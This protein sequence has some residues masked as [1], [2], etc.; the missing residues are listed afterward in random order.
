MRRENWQLPDSLR[1]AQIHLRVSN[2]E[3]AV[4]FYRDLLGF[5]QAGGGDGASLLSPG[6]G[7]SPRIK[8]TDAS[9]A[10][11]RRRG[12]PGLFHVAFRYPDRRALAQELQ[13]LLKS[14]Y[15]VQGAADH[16]VSDALYL[17]DPDGNGVELYC[18]RPRDSW[19]WHGG[20]LA[21][22]T[23][24]LD[25]EALIAEAA[26]PGVGSSEVL[27]DIG[28]IHLQVSDL[29]RSGNFYHDVLGFD[30]T[31]QSFPGA[32]FLSAGGYHHH[33][34]LNTWGT[35]GG[36]AAAP[37]ALGLVSYSLDLGNAEA[38]EVLRSRITSN[39]GPAAVLHGEEGT[40]RFV[41]RDP[42][43]IPVEILRM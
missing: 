32:L 9:S 31:Q 38:F 35:R 1:F 8:L 21:M 23:D 37:D 22:A 19:P 18:D 30:I 43:G 12:T 26:G 40:A 6:R 14:G 29:G 27:P 7:S 5:H 4:E 39:L 20:E 24:P 16:R 41:V 15:P 11:S 33:I 34:G 42:D 13:H 10:P 3:A 17:A 25:I 2:L 36:P 28:H